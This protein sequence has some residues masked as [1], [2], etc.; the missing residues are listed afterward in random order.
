MERKEILEK[1][2]KKKAIVGEMEKAGIN[3][4]NWI[5]LIF[6]GVIAVIFMVVEGTLKHFSAIYAIGGVCYSW[7]SIFYICQFFIAKRPKGVLVGGILHGLGA[8]IMIT[9]YILYNI[10]A[11]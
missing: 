10:G 5:S 9:L 3:K 4:S 7:A 6:A 11:L 2:Q 1:A 8:I